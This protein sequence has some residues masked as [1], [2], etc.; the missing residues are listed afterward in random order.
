MESLAEIDQD[1]TLATAGVS[2]LA[3]LLRVLAA[4]MIYRDLETNK[5][6]MKT[7]G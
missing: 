2:S 4:V 1:G 3:K 5:T 6:Y 7:H